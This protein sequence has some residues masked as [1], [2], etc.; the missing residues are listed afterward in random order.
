MHI[1]LVKSKKGGKN[2]A[3]VSFFQEV[4]VQDQKKIAEIKT[5]MSTPRKTAPV[6]AQDKENKEYVKKW[7]SLLKK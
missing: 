7:C 1:I 4:T 6:H 3:T 2:M 5:A